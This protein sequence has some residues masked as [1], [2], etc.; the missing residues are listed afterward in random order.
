[1]IKFLNK[2]YAALKISV[3]LAVLLSLVPTYQGVQLTDYTPC[4]N[5]HST[6]IDISCLPNTPTNSSEIKIVLNIVFSTVGAI[7]FLIIVIAGFSFVLSRGEPQAVAKAK[8]TII[9]AL[10]G[11]VVCISA[12]SIVNFV[13]GKI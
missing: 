10:V 5:T 11:L 9:Y 1:M 6:S 4:N 12:L 13:V 2:L 3:V 8:D 7:A